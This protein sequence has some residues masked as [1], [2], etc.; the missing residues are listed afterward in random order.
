MVHPSQGSPY[1]P[2]YILLKPTKVRLRIDSLS[3]YIYIREKR[4]R[5]KLEKSRSDNGMLQSRLDE[6]TR[7]TGKLRTET[8]MVRQT[9]EGERDEAKQ[10]YTGA[11]KEVEEALEKISKLEKLLVSKVLLLLLFSYLNDEFL[12]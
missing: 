6:Y 11:V 5:D 7:M 12:P 4:S 8:E 10:L 1:L 3:I 2:C 9:L